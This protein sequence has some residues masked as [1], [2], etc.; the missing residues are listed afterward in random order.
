MEQGENKNLL[1]SLINFKTK[2]NMNNF[3]SFLRKEILKEIRNQKKT[4]TMAMSKDNLWQIMVSKISKHP[5]APKGT[6]SA[7]I[8]RELFN[9]IV[10]N[11]FICH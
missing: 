7:F 11:S 2:N 8:V 9:S 10:P 3:E 5:N 6:N 4:G 1:P